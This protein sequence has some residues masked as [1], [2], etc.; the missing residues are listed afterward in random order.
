M[1]NKNHEQI[2]KRIIEICPTGYKLV[3]TEDFNEISID[4]EMLYLAENGLINIK[5]SLNGEY[6]ICL[7][8]R[9]KNYFDNEKYQN[10]FK[11]DILLKSAVYAFIGGCLG[12]FIA[13]I[14]SFLLGTAL[15]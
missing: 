6:L 4:E 10:E 15:C 7:L 1:L 8:P 11:K 2:L 12:G 5:Y 13:G 3:T 14:I 9:G